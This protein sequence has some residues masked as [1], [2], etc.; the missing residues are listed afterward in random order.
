V[1]SAVGRLG[2]C[3]LFSNLL[4]WVDVLLM[5][6]TCNG[7]TGVVGPDR[8]PMGLCISVITREDSK[9]D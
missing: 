1:I 5:L 3:E 7:D 8:D 6:D 9:D 4:I 2:R